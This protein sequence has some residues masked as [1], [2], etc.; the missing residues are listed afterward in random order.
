MKFTLSWLKTHL[1]TDASLQQITDKLT[2]V[3]LELESVVDRAKALEPF[4][5]AYV[6]EAKPHPDA[7]RLR[8]CMVDT[9]KEK[10]QVVCGAPNARTGMK[11]VFARTGL[12][13]PGTGLLLKSGNI[14][15]QA[16]NG[17]LVS[18]REMG[19]S[20]EHDGIIDLPDDAPVGAPFAKVLGIDDPVIDVAITPNRGDCLGVRGIAR[21][22]A[23]AGLGRLKP[24]AVEPVPGRF[25]SPIGVRIATDGV[26]PAPCP[27]FVG[28]YFHGV[29]N[30]PSPAWLQNWLRAI[31]LRPISALVD[32]TN[33][34][35][36][37]VGRPLHV[38]DA[39]KVKGN[40]TVR[41][42][43]PGEHLLA[44]NGKVYEL[45]GSETVIADDAEPEAL[46]GIIGGEHSGCTEATTDV[47]V[48]AALFDPLRTATTGRKHQINSDARYRF[49]RG[50]DPEAVIE[51]VEAATRLILDL[52]GGEASELVVAGAK[53]QWQRSYTLRLE[54]IF[55][56]GGLGAD[57]EEAVDILTRLGFSVSPSGNAL[58]V[59]PP[60]WR[61][62]I[63]GEAD[64]VEEVTRVAGFDR[65][66]PVPMERLTALPTP[67]I[68]SGQ[69]RTRDAR[70][71]LAG[72]GLVEA[73]TFSF[74][75]RA[76]A[77]LFGFAQPG[78]ILANPIAADLD[79]MRPSL[80][81]MLI[82]AAQ[83]NADRGFGD[84]ALFEVGPIYLDDTAEGQ[85]QVAAAVRAG[86]SPRHWAQA[87]RPVDVIDAK[88]DVV[89]L[90]SALGLTVENLQIA[91]EAPGWYHPGRSGVAKLGP[92]TVV[93]QFGE[94][95]PAVLASLDAKGPVVGCEVFLDRLPQLKAKTSKARP[96]LKLSA[97]QPVERD[98][99]FVLDRGVTADAVIRAAKSVDR[100]LIAGVSVFDLYQGKGVPEGKK[101]LAI[102]VRLQPMDRTLTDDDIE[103]VSQK[104]VAAVAKA[105]GAV[106]RA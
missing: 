94:L 63:I 104:V 47:F 30:G 106:L 65:I 22:L 41:L 24:R 46:G 33:F 5:V 28:R 8:V 20:D 36:F 44:L 96:L 76:D 73:V 49:E 9:G 62:D 51:G 92:K 19:L 38:F 93:A 103:A 91:A 95:H 61:G 83:R 13:I 82:R 60:S 18:E 75:A 81:P 80:L 74:I 66:K 50:V 69:R 21:D 27:M 99:A 58:S 4:T 86:N 84:A 1:E 54:R 101:S 102:S 3:G 48:E 98:F 35:T 6:V 37:D 68:N 97:F 67:A 42:A 87:T 7:D 31:G 57:K 78:L 71:A 59:A 45:D 25:K 12:T 34:L 55:A 79:A 26:D 39:K 53:P 15:G 90:L 32:I 56:L 40:I 23:A 17:M 10:V 2:A 88:G 105:T 29:K 11:G 14:R 70:R 100:A 77:E 64:L 72:F 89:A 43:Q 52:C 85:L 16:S